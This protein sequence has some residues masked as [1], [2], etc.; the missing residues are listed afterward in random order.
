[1]PTPASGEIS[2][3]DIGDEL[4]QPA[5]SL[6]LER[7]YTT[8]AAGGATGLMYHNYDNMGPTGNVSAKN[9]IFDTFNSGANFLTSNWYN[10]DGDPGLVITYLIT[11]SSARGVTLDIQIY[12][13]AGIPVGTVFFGTVGAG[14][15]TGTQT[16]STTC[17]ASSVTAGYRIF[18]QTLD[19]SPPPVA[20]PPPA[21]PNTVTFSVTTTIDSASDTDGVGAGT[22][23]TTYGTFLSSQSDSFPPPPPA[24]VNPFP[25]KIVDTSGGLIFNNKRTTFSITIS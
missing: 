14:I 12:D 4:F 23:R 19:F 24:P 20:N 8:S 6:F 18:I 16:V 13:T 2:F 5:S 22:T 10:Y 11:N 3:E 21:P 25:A 15:N 9:A 1:M 17:L 7:F